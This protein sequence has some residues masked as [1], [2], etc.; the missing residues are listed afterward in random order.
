MYIPKYFNITDEK[1]KYEIIEQNGFA[2]LFSQHNGEPYA[3]HLPLLLNRD[4]RI[5]YGHFARPNEQ[6]KDIGEQKVLAVF[7]G[8][9]CYISPSWYETNKA[10]PTWNYVAVHV[11][12]EMK[13]VE[14]EQELLGSLRDL[15]EKYENPASSYSLDD[16]EPSYIEG[17]SK[18]IVGFKIKIDRIEG[19]RKVSQ[20]HSMERQELVIQQL[21]QI[22]SEDHKGIA[23]LMRENLIKNEEK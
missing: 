13:I 22:D 10:V 15:V 3:T 14:N 20:N 19:K 6:W 4:E 12:G 11:Y 7:Q 17:L 1:T 23:G 5:L 21:E 2:T 8:P 18:G 16:V 9:H